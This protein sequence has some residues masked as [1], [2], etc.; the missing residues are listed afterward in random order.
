MR[1][2]EREAE[3]DSTRI[4]RDKDRH[5]VWIKPSLEKYLIMALRIKMFRNDND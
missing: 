5:S 2:R 3:R 1:Q 4:E